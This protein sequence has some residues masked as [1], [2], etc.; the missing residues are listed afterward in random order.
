MQLKKKPEVKRLTFA[1][2]AATATLLSLGNS[3]VLA[4]EAP[5]E[6]PTQPPSVAAGFFERTFDEVT[7]WA[8]FSGEIGFLSYNE[9]GR[10]SAFE[11]SVIL[12]ARFSGDRTWTNHFTVDSL[13]GSSPNGAVPSR[14]A[15]TF[16]GPSGKGTYSAGPGETPLDPKF[17]DTRLAYSTSWSQPLSESNVAM[18]GAGISSEYD[19][20]SYSFNVADS[21]DFNQKNTSVSVG[22]SLEFDQ[23]KAVGGAP[24]G[25]DTMAAKVTNQTSQSKTV[26]DFLAG[27][28]QVFSRRLI[29]QFNYSFGKADGYMNDPYK[30]VSEVAPDGSASAGDATGT[31]YYE[32]RPDQR[33]RNSLFASLKYHL[34]SWGIV[35]GSYRYFWDDWGV[36]SHTV[37]VGY[38]IPIDDV[39]HAGFDLRY[40]HQGQAD[41]YRPFLVQGQALPAVVS[42]DYRLGVMDSYTIGLTLGRKIN[43]QK[44]DLTLHL[45][46][47][48]QVPDAHPGA[49]FG[50][51]DPLTLV[52][53]V[54]V[55]IAKAVFTY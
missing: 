44:N 51:L 50:S 1:L 17:E 7:S 37:S 52:P 54:Q 42:A 36:K 40:Y 49:S 32:K 39:W 23:S 2:S 31:Y 30:V 3:F 19:Y 18:V 48:N 11:P 16:T 15:Q 14:N 12:S 21:H 53:S 6:L 9:S 55:V 10:V 28:T 47:Y 8:K 22:A 43:E 34:L 4:N 45:Q 46:Y 41:F 20:R 29:G 35:T 24:S 27:I 33:T 26:Y 38:E 13:T 25:L 5:T